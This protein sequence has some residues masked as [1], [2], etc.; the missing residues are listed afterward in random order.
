MFSEGREGFRFLE[1]TTDALVEAWGPTIE[2]AFAQAAA[3]FFETFLNLEK[4]N[5]IAEEVVDAS[6]HDEIELLYNWLEELLLRFELKGMAYSVFEVGPPSRAADS[7]G[8]RAKVRGERYDRA[9]HGGKV[10]I[11]GI[12]YHLME[13]N[14]IDREVRVSFLLDL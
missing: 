2:R 6:G 11:K 10:E 8:L 13:I 12:T 4:V 14:R 3:G 7:F 1:H 9:K 5:P